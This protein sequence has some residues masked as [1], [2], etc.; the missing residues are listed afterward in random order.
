MLEDIDKDE[1][2]RKKLINLLEKFKSSQ[3]INDS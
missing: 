1:N 3:P 2:Q